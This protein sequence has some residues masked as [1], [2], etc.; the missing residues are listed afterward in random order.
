MRASDRL[1]HQGS[2]QDHFPQ[3]AAQI[4]RSKSHAHGRQACLQDSFMRPEDEGGKEAAQLNEG[5][6]RGQVRVC[7]A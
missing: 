7:E 3:A 6:L 4:C 1:P 2:R 5:S